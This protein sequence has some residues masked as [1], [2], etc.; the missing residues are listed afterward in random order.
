VREIELAGDKILDKRIRNTYVET[1]IRRA[2]EPKNK[3]Q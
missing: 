3:E 1:G 2:V